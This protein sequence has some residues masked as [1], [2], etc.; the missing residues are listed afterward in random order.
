MEPNCA[1]AVRPGAEFGP[2]PEETITR[3]FQNYCVDKQARPVPGQPQP[4]AQRVLYHATM[5]ALWVGAA[6]LLGMLA[7][8]LG[9]PPLVGYLAAG[10]ALNALGV[11]GGEPLNRIA[12]YGVLL[13][14]FGVGL[15]LHWPSLLRLEV[16]GVGGVHLLLAGALLTLLLAG[17]GQDPFVAVFLGLGLAFS[18]TVL[19]VKLLEEKRELSVY[20]GRVTV[21]ILILQDLVAVG[22]LAWAGVQSPSPW[23]LLLLL[24]PLLR[25]LVAWV[26]EK[27]GHDELLLLYGLGLALGGAGLSQV[28]GLSPELG[29]LLMG[30]V[31]AGHPKTSELSRILWGLKEAFLVAFFLEIG[32]RQLPGLE[33]L[34][35]G[36]L[37][38]LFLP[39][40][41]LLFL[42]LFI[43]FGLRARTAF[44][45]ALSLGSYSEFAL[46]AAAVAIENGR[47]AED[48]GP[49]LGLVVAASLALAAPLN[50]AAHHIY[51]RLDPWL[52][53]LERP[54][55][56][57]DREP[58]RLGA[59]R[60]LLVG[61]GR[62]GG[63]AYK[64]LEARGERVV[65]LDADPAKLERH[66]AR[67]LRVLYGDAEDPELWERLDLSGVRG[68]L[69]TLPD[70]EAKLRAIQ[71]LRQ[72]GYRGL[73]AATSY[74][75]EEDMV[76][77]QAGVDLIFHPFVEAGER[78][79]ERVLEK[80]AQPPAPEPR[81]KQG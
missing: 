53:R 39:V 19:A 35:Q 13:L 2:L 50:R 60:W 56:H 33:A 81:P 79:A 46:I 68:V 48:W 14:L 18:S 55:P 6:Y 72:R 3:A 73:V 71:S 70:L 59:A 27:S 51:A 15:K 22:L 23:A 42:G 21:G 11:K 5:E 66:R 9:L 58:T 67:G 1:P 16:L 10:F 12:G 41:T 44:V 64:L 40:K 76:L 61:M 31:L 26:L 54:G 80:L 38:L 52:L 4:R 45:A 32:L 65:G 36:A 29:A 37:L 78:L 43:V 25:P 47:I 7:S 74:H 77:G 69:L 30:A 75:H 62:T 20:H 8:R 63:A 28:V 57:P 49:L 17:F 24:L 34:A